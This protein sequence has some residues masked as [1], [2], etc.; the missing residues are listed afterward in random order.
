MKI[1]LIFSNHFMI[2]TSGKIDGVDLTTN[3]KWA[4]VDANKN[5]NHFSRFS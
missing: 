1:E 2:S 4:D 3:V 5:Q